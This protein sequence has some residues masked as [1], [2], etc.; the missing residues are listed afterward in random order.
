M[1]NYLE[2]SLTH[3][4]SFKDGFFGYKILG[5]QIFFN[6]NTL[7]M[8]S[9]ACWPPLFLMRSQLLLSEINCK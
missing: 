2:M 7:N 3:S 5:R 4:H 8:L 6:L 1:G 9:P